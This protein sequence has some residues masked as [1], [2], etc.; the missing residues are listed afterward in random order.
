M[1]ATWCLLQ[2]VRLSGQNYIWGLWASIFMRFFFLCSVRLS[3]LSYQRF[4]IGL[5]GV[6]VF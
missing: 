3:V 4:F 6:K 1:I 2:S 5:S